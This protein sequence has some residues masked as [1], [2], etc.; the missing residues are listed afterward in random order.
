MEILVMGGTRFFGRRL[1]HLLLKD[2]HNVTIATRGQ[3]L[4]DFGDKVRR[5]QID[6]SDQNSMAR[7]FK[8][9]YYDVVFDQI[10]FN[11]KEAKIAVE[12]FGDRIKRYVFTSSMAVYGHK[13]GEISEDDFL[14]EDY[15]FDLDAD[16]YAYSEGK[17]Q[18][19]AYF[20]QYAKFPVVAVRVAMVVSG[21]DD[22]TGRL[23]YYVSHV[24]NRESI[25]VFETEHP[26]TYVTAWDIADFLKFIGTQT[27]YRGPINAGNSGYLSIQELSHK[28]GK[29]LGVFPLFHV[30]HPN[31]VEAPL[32][33]YAMFPYTWCLSNAKAKSLGYEFPDIE[34]SIPRMVEQSIKRICKDVDKDERNNKFKT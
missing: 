22:Y 7:A 24:A 31:S 1:V 12:T 5:I 4:D 14:P 27:D 18:A 9:Q 30:G 32:S 3:T 23:D 25:G 21:N 16:N 20:F 33:P 19:E 17:R 26:I 11:P 15:S 29:L 8:D 28:I 13:E 10:C 2:G 6:R 34:N